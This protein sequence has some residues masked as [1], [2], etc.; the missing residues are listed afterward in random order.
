MEGSVATVKN[1]QFVSGS[2]KLAA[3]PWLGHSQSRL[4]EI[5]S[6]RHA[7]RNKACS[8][9]KFTPWPLPSPYPLCVTLPC[10][11]EISKLHRS[12]WPSKTLIPPPLTELYLHQSF[13]S[14]FPLML[15]DVIPKVLLELKWVSDRTITAPDPRPAYLS[16]CCSFQNSPCWTVSALTSTNGCLDRSL[17]H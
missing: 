14:A 12:L 9:C 17:F 4:M 16:L 6:I 13:Q 7:S 11:Q 5:F 2:G 8:H 15:P 1:S 3:G 10:G